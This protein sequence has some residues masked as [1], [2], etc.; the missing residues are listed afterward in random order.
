MRHA[1][2]LGDGG[3]HR[4]FRL[5]KIGDDAGFQPARAQVPDAQHA[6]PAAGTG[7]LGRIEGG[8]SWIDRLTARSHGR[9][10]RV[11]E[12][13][14]RLVGGGRVDLEVRSQGLAE[15]PGTTISV[16]RLGDM[17][18]TLPPAD[19]EELT[20]REREVSELVAEA[21]TDAEIAER[22]YLSAHTVRQHIKAVY[23][24]LGISSRVALTRL[25]LAA[26]PRD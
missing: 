18:A 7:T 26:P 6:R 15:F 17:R 25:V 19:L 2:G 9:V 12:A 5:G 11:A 16:L 1:L 3:A 23:R 24:K 14:V 20:A 21:L 22:L 4:R 10:P 13:E 8:E